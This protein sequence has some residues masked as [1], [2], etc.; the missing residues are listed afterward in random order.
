MVLY[1]PNTFFKEFFNSILQ[2]RKQ[3]VKRLSNLKIAQQGSSKARMQTSACLTL[4]PVFLTLYCFMLIKPAGDAELWM[5]WDTWKAVIIFWIRIENK[6]KRQSWG[7]ELLK[8]LTKRREI[9]LT[10]H[11]PRKPSTDDRSYRHLFLTEFP[12]GSKVSCL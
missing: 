10:L 3:T 12:W 2:M 5:T 11:K 1:A 7:Y 4:K 6:F 8:G 9:R